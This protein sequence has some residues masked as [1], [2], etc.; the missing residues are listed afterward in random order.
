L[1]NKGSEGLAVLTSVALDVHQSRTACTYLKELG[2]EKHIP[3]AALEPDFM[4]KAEM[5]RWL[6]HPS[7]LGKPPLSLEVFD[8]RDLYWPPL[9][10]KTRVWLFRFTYQFENDPKPQT[11]YG[12]V[13]GMTW[14]SFTE[15]DSAP[16]PE[17]LYV[18]HCALELSRNAETGGGQERKVGEAEAREEL[19]KG[20][21]GMF[22]K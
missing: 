7:E 22:T 15:Y 18:S 12:M 17:A 20:N 1:K 14:S 19:N 3:A 5:S 9:K 6:Q 13:G 8:S 16:T 10:E 11:G 21:P 2:E 4:A